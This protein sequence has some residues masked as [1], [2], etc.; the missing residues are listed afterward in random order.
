MQSK[1]T[2][3]AI[4]TLLASSIVI[5]AGCGGRVADPVPTYRAGDEQMSC[6]E[7]KTEMAYIEGE[8]NKLIPESKKTG[9]NVALG[10]A[11]LFLIF[12]WFFMDMS[13]A[14]KTEIRAYNE[15]YL[16]LE[17][18]YKTKCLDAGDGQA[19]SDRSAA[20]RLRLLDE[21]KEEGLITEAEYEKRRSE[22]IAEL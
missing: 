14:E 6:S 1:T 20:E 5:T 22:I 15:R 3:F 16:A 19:A 12:P 21:L 18:L 2:Q 17:K 4:V 13:D 9:K 8:V 11:G 10:A 7:L